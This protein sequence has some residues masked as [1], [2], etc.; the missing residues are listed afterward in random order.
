MSTTTITRNGNTYATIRDDA[1]QLRVT[2]T[3][4]TPMNL[5]IEA[6]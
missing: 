6:H 5:V 2:L 1:K 3:K 4:N